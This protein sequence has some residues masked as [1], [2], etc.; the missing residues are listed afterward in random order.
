MWEVF[1]W[2][3]ALQRKIMWQKSENQLYCGVAK[4][5]LFHRNLDKIGE[6]NVAVPLSW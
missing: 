6:E 3:G 1:L 4:S 2:V 5:V